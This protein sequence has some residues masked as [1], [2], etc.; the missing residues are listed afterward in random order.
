MH[1]RKDIFTSCDCFEFIN[2]TD[3]VLEQ[4]MP[5]LLHPW[6]PQ[7]TISIL[8]MAFSLFVIVLNF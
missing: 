7:R 3:F 4:F 6:L 5:R 1:F 8:G 2:L